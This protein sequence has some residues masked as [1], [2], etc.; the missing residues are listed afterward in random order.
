MEN[1]TPP[2]RYSYHR[3]HSLPDPC[4]EE[5]IVSYDSIKM[6]LRRVVLGNFRM[7]A[8]IPTEQPAIVGE[9]I[10]SDE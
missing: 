7:F 5:K 9:A 10:V 1:C 8:H 3:R 6:R 4:C 2:N